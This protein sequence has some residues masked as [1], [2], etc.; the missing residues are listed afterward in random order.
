M[1]SIAQLMRVMLSLWGKHAKLVQHTE[2]FAQECRNR[3]LPYSSRKL[4][5][6][7]TC[8]YIFYGNIFIQCVRHNYNDVIQDTDSDSELPK[9]DVG[10]SQT[11]KK[12]E[13]CLANLRVS[14]VISL[15]F[16]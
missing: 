5:R 7:C 10:Y 4:T 13:K 11:L 3:I 16:K 2:G 1:P 9:T 15:V 14:S 12:A 8:S 6:Q